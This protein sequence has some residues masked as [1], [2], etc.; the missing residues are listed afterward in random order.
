MVGRVLEDLV[1]SFDALDVDKNGYL[2]AS[3]FANKDFAKDGGPA[4][5]PNLVCLHLVGYIIM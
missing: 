5:C 2:E 3:D 1:I 4:R